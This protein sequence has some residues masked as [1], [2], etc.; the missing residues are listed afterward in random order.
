MR[1]NE[2]GSACDEPPHE[3]PSPAGCWKLL[4]GPDAERDVGASSSRARGNGQAPS[5]GPS[6]DEQVPPSQGF[7]SYWGTHRISPTPYAFGPGPVSRLRTGASIWRL[8]A[9]P[10]RPA[11]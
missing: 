8:R 3:P 5:E 10:A 1:P 4:L 7:V 9:G 6:V 2:P 11:R